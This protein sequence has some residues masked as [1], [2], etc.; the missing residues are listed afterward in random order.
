MLAKHIQNRVDRRIM[1]PVVK[2]Q[3]DYVVIGVNCTFHVQLFKVLLRKA[4]ASVIRVYRAFTEISF[5]QFIHQLFMGRIGRQQRITFNSLHIVLFRDRICPQFSL[6][7]KNFANG[8]QPV[9]RIVLRI[10]SGNV[11]KGVIGNV[12]DLFT[13]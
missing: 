5:T 13:F 2:G 4:K 10:D 7:R 1:S 6:I 11:V 9:S 8:L 3:E 12:I